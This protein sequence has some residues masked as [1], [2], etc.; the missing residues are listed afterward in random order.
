MKP[1]ALF[2]GLLLAGAALAP[3]AASA[4]P[5]IDVVASEVLSV[6]PPRIRTTFTVEQVGYAPCPIQFF[7]IN[8][9]GPDPKPALFECAAPAGWNCGPSLPTDAGGR[10][11]AGIHEGWWSP[12]MTFSIVS[13]REAPCVEFIF[14]DPVLGRVP[15]PSLAY[16]CGVNA[17]L[18]LD[19]PVP[20]TQASWGRIK[21]TYR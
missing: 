7:D 18:V 9:G 13:D 17:C 14:W 12:V 20:T 19:A 11:F 21:S 16:S 15:T 4:W 5:S 8:P 1:I 10:Y 2:A 3:T 6:D